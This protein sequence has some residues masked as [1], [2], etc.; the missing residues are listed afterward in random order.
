MD[1]SYTT[2]G[3]RP[4]LIWARQRQTNTLRSTLRE[5]YPAALVAFGDDLSSADALAILGQA[6]RPDEGQRLSRS[7]IEAAGRRGGSQ[8][9]A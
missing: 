4:N 5:F 9:P 7:K 6:P 8:A 3:T 1:F 2:D